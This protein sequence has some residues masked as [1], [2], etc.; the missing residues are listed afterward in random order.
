LILILDHR[1]RFDRLWATRLGLAVQFQ[2]MDVVSLAV[3]K[4]TG[5]SFLA[6]RGGPLVER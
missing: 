4:R 3:E 5:Q 6:E 2:D 1:F